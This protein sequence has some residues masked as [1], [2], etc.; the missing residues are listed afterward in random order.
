MPKNKA[1]RNIW[2][3]NCAGRLLVID[4]PLIMG[5]IN[6][7]E[8]SFYA[9]SR[10]MQTDDILRTAETMLQQGA[11]ILDLG[12]QSTRP[13][14]QP[15]SADEEWQRLQPAIAALK[16]H[17]PE[18]YLS[19]DTYYASVARRAVDAGAEI[20][21]D[22]SAGNMD[23]DMIA[24]VATLRVPYVIMHMQGTPATMQL[25]PHYEDVV[26]EIT[27]FFIEKVAIC[28]QVGIH[29]LIVDPGFGFGKN[30]QHN[31]TLLRHLHVF[32][33]MDLPLLVGISRKSMIYRL[34]G[35]TSEQALNGTTAL[36]MLALEQGA[37]ILR[38]HDV[39]E[40]N[41]VIRLWSYYH[42]C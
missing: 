1:F 21:N 26:K 7:T 18:A 32:H 30:L 12:A 38:V 27:A 33:V 31:Y 24:T 17:F 13:G 28:R 29:D 36:H 11:A 8:D 41:E 6:I 40:A 3:L 23:Q 35:T 25:N 37:H 2:T 34:L 10:H 20:I 42:E 19:V 5:I 39:R 15:I 14:A 4:Q 9:G 16:K 22:I